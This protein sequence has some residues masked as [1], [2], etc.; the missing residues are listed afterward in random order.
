MVERCGNPRLLRLIESHWGLAECVDGAAERGMANHHGSC[1][2]HDAII[3]AIEAGRIDQAADL[4]RRH[5]HEGIGVV[6]KWLRG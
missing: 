5:W 2:Q 6:T 1:E 3:D 4:L